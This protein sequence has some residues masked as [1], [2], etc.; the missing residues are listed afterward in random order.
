[1]RTKFI[2]IIW[3]TDKENPRIEGSWGLSLFVLFEPFDVIDKKHCCSWGLSLFVL[4]ERKQHGLERCV[5]SW[6]LSLF[7]LF[8]P[9]CLTAFSLPVLE[10]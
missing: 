5:R 6:G 4:F 3:T 8:E 1:M 10:D 9:F 2:C 7:V